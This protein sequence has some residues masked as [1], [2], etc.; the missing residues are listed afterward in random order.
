MDY[1]IQSQA[2]IL[3]EIEDI[4]KHP[5]NQTVGDVA[6]LQREYS[7]LQYQI[8][9]DANLRTMTE[10]AKINREAASKVV[11]VNPNRK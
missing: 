5:T 11:N 10:A 7:N 3:K 1:R 8:E 2:I 9:T 4:I 6:E